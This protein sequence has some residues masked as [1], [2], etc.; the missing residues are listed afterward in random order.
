VIQLSSFLDNHFIIGMFLSPIGI[1]ALHL[2]INLISTIRRKIDL[3]FEMSIALAVW[4]LIYFINAI[5]GEPGFVDLSLLHLMY[6]FTI[7][8]LLIAEVIFYS[9]NESSCV[10]I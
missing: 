9:R 2:V 6:L 5:Y 3:F 1:F 4:A 7:L 8:W 10:G